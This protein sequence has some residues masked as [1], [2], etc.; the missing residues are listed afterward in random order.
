MRALEGERP[1]A[2]TTADVDPR[3]ADPSADPSAD[4]GADQPAG[5]AAERGRL[6]R[7]WPF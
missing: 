6:D 3:R 5:P 7:L 2:P 4:P 1:T